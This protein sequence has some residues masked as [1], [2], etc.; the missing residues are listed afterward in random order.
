MAALAANQKRLNDGHATLITLENDPTIK[1]FEKEV[2]PPAINAGG[3]IE[4]STMRNVS[5]HTKAPKKL[6]GVGQT[7]ASCAYA[8]ESI[9]RIYAQLGS[10]QRITVTYPDGSRYRY[11]GWLDSFTPGSNTMGA[12]PTAEVVFEA[13]NVNNQDQEAPPEYHA[14]AEETSTESES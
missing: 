1:L 12:Q 11:W 2:T 10:N 3:P 7:K 14:P 8:T 4:T 6:K 5:V 13:S 9:Q